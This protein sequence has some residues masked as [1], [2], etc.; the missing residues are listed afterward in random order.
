MTPG[1]P[2]LRPERAGW[3]RVAKRCLDG[4]WDDVD[5]TTAGIV[6][7]VLLSIQDPSCKAAVARLKRVVMDR[8]NAHE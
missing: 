4:K 8:G 5:A 1:R 6:I 3:I 2:L 7:N